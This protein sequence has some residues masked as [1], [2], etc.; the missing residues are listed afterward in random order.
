MAS[1]YIIIENPKTIE[2]CE[3]TEK[4]RSLHALVEKETSKFYKI[5]IFRKKTLEKRNNKKKIR[6]NTKRHSGLIKS[7][8]I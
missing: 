3:G 2:N 6:G 8:E 1:T 7:R 4:Y 5:F